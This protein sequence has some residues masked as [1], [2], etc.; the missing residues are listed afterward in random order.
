MIDLV[1]DITIKANLAQAVTIAV[2]YPLLKEELK[3]KQSLAKYKEPVKLY[4]RIGKRMAQ[5]EARQTLLE[6]DLTLLRG[7]LELEKVTV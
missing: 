1:N 2:L 4:N 7:Q 3:Y 6:A 5:L